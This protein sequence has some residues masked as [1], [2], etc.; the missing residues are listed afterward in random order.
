MNVRPKHYTWAAFYDNLLDTE[1]YAYSWRQI[2]RRYRVNEPGVATWMNVVRAISSERHGRVAYHQR[3][4]S[5]L[6]SDRSV[7]RFFDQETTVVPRYYVDQVRH[8]LGSLWDA[9]PEGGLAHDPNAY[10]A[11]ECRAPAPAITTLQAI[12]TLEK[13][14]GARATAA[15]S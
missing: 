14:R 8:D 1:R 11:S 15:T 9:L 7:R 12:T 6:D 3:I 10:L 2:G 5:L 4:R 13:P